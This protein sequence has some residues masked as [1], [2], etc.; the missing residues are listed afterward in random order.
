MG[1]YAIFLVL[2]LTF[3]MLTYSYAL[4][5]SIFISN[6]RTVQSFSYNQ[7]HNIAQGAAMIAINGIRSGDITYPDNITRAWVEMNGEY[8]LEISEDSEN[9]EVIINSSGTFFENGQNTGRT[10][11]YE[12]SVGLSVGTTIWELDLHQALHAE[13]NIDLGSGNAHVD[14]DVTINGRN[15]NFGS[16]NSMDY[17]IDGRL[18]IGP[19]FSTDDLPSNSEDKVKGG[20]ESIGVMDK[21]L[22]FDMPDFPVYSEKWKNGNKNDIENTTTINAADYDGTRIGRIDLKGNN[23]LTQLSQLIFWKRDMRYKYM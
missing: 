5:N 4:R 16:G 17:K 7:A 22:S 21:N 23:S 9:N 6:E 13:D 15:I 3:S 1:K 19:D 12:I 18:D 20:A 10:V 8:T 2:A 14:G 11:N